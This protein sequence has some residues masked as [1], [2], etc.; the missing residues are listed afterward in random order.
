MHMQPPVRP[1]E[2][3]V[4]AEKRQARETPADTDC[5]DD[6]IRSIPSEIPVTASADE[7]APSHGIRDPSS[8][9]A[10]RE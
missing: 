9:E 4:H 2:D 6:G 7:V 8:R 3:P 1:D 5:A 10:F